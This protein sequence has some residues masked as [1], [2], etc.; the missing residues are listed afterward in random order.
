MNGVSSEYQHDTGDHCSD[1]DGPGMG[2][3]LLSLYTYIPSVLL[4]NDI[5]FVYMYLHTAIEPDN[6]SCSVS[7]GMVLSFFTGADVI[8][9]QGYMSALLNFNAVNQY[10]TALTCAIQLTLSTKHSTYSEYKKHLDV[11]FTIHGGFGLV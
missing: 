6:Q 1:I 2:I 4:Y 10:P 8:P 5:F 9:P 7:L 3:W 11:A